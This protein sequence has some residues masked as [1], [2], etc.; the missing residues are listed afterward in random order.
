MT[1]TLRQISAA[2]AL[3]VGLAT[4]AAGGALAQT[5]AA[6]AESRNPPQ[7]VPPL[8]AAPPPSPAALTARQT[9]VGGFEGG[10][11]VVALDFVAADGAGPA[12]NAGDN[13]AR[14]WFDATVY[15]LG[16]AY[17]S[18]SDGL[19]PPSPETFTKSFKSKNP[20]DFWQL[21]GDAGYKLKEIATD[22]GVVPDVG[23]KFRYVRELSDGDINW[24]ERKLRKHEEKYHDPLSYAQRAIIYTLLSINS[25]DVYFVEELKVKLLPLPTARFALTPW[26]SGLSWEHDTL[27]RA[28]QGQKHVRRKPTEE[29]SHY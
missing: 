4:G 7:I 15:W 16:T 17:T 18:I 29:E 2:L 6:S 1:K 14:R 20:D 11:Q 28:I 27:L 10:A 25:S 21:V 23:F 26:D 12:G 22:V 19:T 5:G 8:A 9:V 3:A 24:L 13:L